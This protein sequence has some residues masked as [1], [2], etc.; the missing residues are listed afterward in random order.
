MNEEKWIKIK[1]IFEINLDALKQIAFNQNIA[2]PKRLKKLFGELNDE[3][4]IDK[5]QL[6]VFLAIDNL[7]N[8]KITKL[9]E[10]IN[11][12]E[13]KFKDVIG[14]YRVMS[15][16]IALLHETHYRIVSETVPEIANRQ[17]LISNNL[18]TFNEARNFYLNENY[19]NE[20]AL[21]TIVNADF[22]S[23]ENELLI[24]KN[25]I[26]SSEVYKELKNKTSDIQN[27][28][29]KYEH[30]KLLFN[31]EL[32]D[33]ENQR[34]APL[35]LSAQALNQLVSEQ[36][37]K[38]NELS[39]KVT[40]FET[41]IDDIPET[42]NQNVANR[43]ESFSQKDN[44]L[45]QK[46]MQINQKVD[47][48]KSEQD[49]TNLANN[50]KFLQC[51][52]KIT[53][54]ETKS[55]Q[56]EQNISVIRNKLQE[57]NE[58]H[59]NNIKELQSSKITADY[60]NDKLLNIEDPTQ[61][62]HAANKKYID[63]I[64]ERVP[65]LSTNNTFS[66]RNTFNDNVSFGGSLVTSSA[67]ITQ[68]EQVTNKRY[69]DTKISEQAQ[70]IT[71]IEQS[72]G[73]TQN[74]NVLTTQNL[75]AVPREMKTLTIVPASGNTA[76][77]F[78]SGKNNTKWEFF[79]DGGSR[80]FGVFNKSGNKYALEIKQNGE[81][82]T[83]GVLNVNNNKIT[84]LANP[85]NEKDAVN[86]KYVDDNKIDILANTAQLQENN[87]FNGDNTF[88]GNVQINRALFL[89]DTANKVKWYFGTTADG[90]LTISEFD[91]SDNIFIL[92]K[93]GN[94]DE[95]C[96]FYNYLKNNYVDKNFK[97]RVLTNNVGTG[98]I[99]IN[100]KYLDDGSSVIIPWPTSLETNENTLYL[101]LSLTVKGSKV[102]DYLTSTTF[103]FLF[104]YKGD[105][106]Q[107]FNDILEADS[108]LNFYYP[109]GTDEI[110]LMR[111]FANPETD[112]VKVNHQVIK[113]YD[114]T[115]AYN[116]P[117][118]FEYAWAETYL[119]KQDA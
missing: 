111:V 60:V 77:I 76:S 101:R 20:Q 91:S 24:W 39:D 115:R 88:Q 59:K 15:V 50:S 71:A 78:L 57:A 25:R 28:L 61:P 82:K 46:Y 14:V 10:A 27:L 75:N 21:R 89:I 62:T 66:G 16:H 119:K 2:I 36:I 100:S 97:Y 108:S 4:I 80:N 18:N 118:Q 26:E 6:H 13:T 49:N 33:L 110:F 35:E 113:L 37:N 52:E 81:V 29:G 68:N 65:E 105:N 40:T 83:F 9:L 98:Q 56:N 92:N 73:F 96:S 54:L 55:S 3:A 116:Q 84:N 1:N 7:V 17:R 19:L 58:E 8:N 104:S 5:M 64:I 42:I 74:E 86:K 47:N 63:A 23:L 53:S 102:N 11:Y 70:R 107:G 31:T 109:N 44:E 106:I 85:Q 117:L 32:N 12:D 93:N 22:E 99:E 67:S 87:Y 51:K 48:F 90:N 79:S 94:L 38:A 72:P 95:N 103:R 34:I 69:V 41:K 30:L 43:L 45:E 114:G 112:G